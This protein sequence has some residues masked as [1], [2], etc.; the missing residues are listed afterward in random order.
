[1]EDALRSKIATLT[2]ALQDVLDS[3]TDEEIASRTGA[4]FE[5]LRRAQMAL[6]FCHGPVAI[7]PGPAFWRNLETHLAEMAAKESGKPLS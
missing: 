3:F 7:V 6:D 5:V 4:R 2:G 1:M